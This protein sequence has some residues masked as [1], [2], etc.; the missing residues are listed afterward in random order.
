MKRTKTKVD[1]VDTNV[2]W[3]EPSIVIAE[4]DENCER[5]K[6]VTIVFRYPWEVNSIRVALDRV[7]KYWQE[8]AS[9]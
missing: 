3:H 6:E 7:T 2:G 4:T 1:S 8:A 5:V 9:R